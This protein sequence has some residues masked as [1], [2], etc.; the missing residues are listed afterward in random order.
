MLEQITHDIKHQ[1]CCPN[2]HLKRVQFNALLKLMQAFLREEILSATYK[3]NQ[4]IFSLPRTMRLL[5]VDMIQLGSLARYRTFGKIFIKE[6]TDSVRQITNPIELLDICISELELEYDGGKWEKFS[7]EINNHLRNALLSSYK[8]CDLAK[9]IALEAKKNGYRYFIQWVTNHHDIQDTTIFFEQWASRGHPHHPCSKTKLGFSIED[10]VRYSP[11]FHPEVPIMVAAIRRDFM[12]IETIAPQQ[13]YVEW[14][15]ENFPDV[16]E[17]WTQ[18][19]QA[20]DLLVDDY[21]PVPVH[22]W[23][24]EKKLTDIFKEFIENGI[25]QLLGD[26]CILAAPTLSFRTLAPINRQNTAYI[27]LPIAVQATSVFRTLSPGSTENTPKIS[28]L[29][30]DILRKE[31]HFGGRLFILREIYGLHLNHISDE[32]A[33]HLTTIYRENPNKYLAPNE[34]CIVVAALFEKSPVTDTALF[35]ELMHSAGIVYLNDA[36]T[37][38]RQ[39]VDLVLGSYLDLYL[40]YGIALEGHQQNTLAVFSD[41]RIS[42]FISRDF[43]GTDIHAE[44]L[45]NRDMTFKAYPGSSNLWQEKQHVRNSLLHA[46]Y[47]SHL[48][49]LA[50][51]LANHFKCEEKYF[52]QEIKMVTEERFHELKYKMMPEIWMMEYQAI[53]ETDWPCKALLRM[54]LQKKYS[55]EGLFF[56]IANPL[57]C[58]I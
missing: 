2:K 39:Y 58:T 20:K 26:V 24:A 48:G 50:L 8:S 18:A 27:K 40:I 22:P 5:Y 45:Q 23:Q 53:L 38:F 49:E 35:I 34:I 57:S 10:V 19:L 41:G 25:L 47:Q 3:D 6:N 16:W 15:G 32:Q 37:Y 21:I 43:D 42:R 13:D 12:H 46:V 30:S 52:W 55:P 54:R 51:L 44:T 1:D 31:N 56:K 9:R 17:Q 36:I 11:E 14:F 7:Q 4:L 28:R 33:K 29:L